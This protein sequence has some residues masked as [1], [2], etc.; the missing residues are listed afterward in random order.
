[1]LAILDGLWRK[2]KSLTGRNDVKKL[3]EK[4]SNRLFQKV[5]MGKLVDT[6]VICTNDLIDDEFTNGDP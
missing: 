4:G 2:L 5:T 3:A 6:V 1:M